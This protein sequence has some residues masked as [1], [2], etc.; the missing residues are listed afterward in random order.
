MEPREEILFLAR[1]MTKVPDNGDER[2]RRMKSSLKE[3]L[4]KISQYEEE[5]AYD[6][7]IALDER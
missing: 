5:Y 3:S 1:E 7:S 2:I 6:Q 4:Q